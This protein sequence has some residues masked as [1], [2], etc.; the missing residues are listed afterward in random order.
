MIF[1]KTEDE[2]GLIRE[3]C[4]LVSKTIAEV[5]RNIKPGISAA[6]LD[7][8]ARTFIQ[9]NG[10]CPAFL[11]YNNFPAALCVSLNN[12]IAHGLPT[13]DKIIKEGDLVSVDCGIEYNG[14]YSDI[15]YTFMIGNIDSDCFNLCKTTYTA[16]KKG[17]T[18]AIDGNRLGDIGYA[19]QKHVE[20]AGYSVTRNMFGHGIGRLLH[21]DPDVPNY[22]KKGRGVLLMDGMVM[23]I[24][25]MV[26]LGRPETATA[27]DGWT[28]R[29]VDNKRSAHFEHTIAIRRGKAEIL[30]SFNFV[31]KEIEINNYLWQN[32]F[33]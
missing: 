8:I 19:I 15:C 13:E 4:L 17:I 6:N 18:K 32:S 31:R 12:E 29:T 2:I 28:V 11:G 21:E 5:A 30:T 14:F 24:E 22:G 25:P 9:N 10:A 1:L 33:L 7:R 3:S 16:L 27:D 20:K 26:N 23:S